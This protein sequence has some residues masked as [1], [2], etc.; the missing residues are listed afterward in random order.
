MR[1]M[2]DLIAKE[3]RAM[4]PEEQTEW[5]KISARCDAIEIDMGE[6]RKQAD[7]VEQRRKQIEA[8][9]A[10]QQRLAAMA[11]APPAPSGGQTPSTETR[12][13]P[14]PVEHSIPTIEE[15]RNSSE[16]RAAFGQRAAPEYRDA[17][18]SFL[19]YG[20]NR[21]GSE[22]RAM[23]MDIDT[24]GGFLLASE[25]FVAQLIKFVNNIVFVRQKATVYPVTKAESLGVPSLDTDVADPDWTGEIVAAGEDSSLTVGKRTLTP[26]PLSKLVKVSRTLLQRAII[27]PETLVSER[28]A[29]KFAVVEEN[30]FL[31]G[32]GANQP[33]GVFT[34]SDMGVT[35]SRDVSTDNTTTAVTADGL[36]NA[37]YSLKVQYWPK[38]EWIFN[39]TVVRDIRK[40]KDGNGQYLWLAGLQGDRPSTILE[41]PYS[42]SE[43]APN[44]M[45][46]GLYVGIIGDFS[47]YWIADALNYELQRLDE[48]F[49]QTNQV[50]FIGRRAVDGMPVLAEAF[51]RVKLA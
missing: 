45:T 4:S 16:Y 37:K 29:Y 28:L 24:T 49:A 36:I 8:A 6:L 32:T 25:E 38:A 7:A 1:E 41:T 43:Y 19:R 48:L 33:L 2:S 27:S 35:T 13:T 11:P 31:N 3:N 14:P 46:T 50:G 9:E 12:K 5:D 42:M 47:F 44:T 18:R 15:Y 26:R 51:A 34:A 21:A 23:Q 40:L 22:F 30:A 17:F 39:R 20:M 10:R